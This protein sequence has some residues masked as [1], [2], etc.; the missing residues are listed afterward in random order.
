MS[1]LCKR[2]PDLSIVI[3]AYNIEDCITPMLDSLKAQ[4]IGDYLVE[5]IFVLNNC[6]DDTEGVIRRSGLDCQLI[7]CEIQGC[8]PARNAGLDIARGEY[9][10][11]IDGDDWLMSDTAIRQILDRVKRDN[12]DI[13]RIPFSH[14]KYRYNYFSM[15]WQYVMRREFIN[16]FR[17]PNYQPA[18]DDAFMEMVLRKAGLDRH[19]YMF[20]PHLSEELYYYNYLRPG[21]NMYRHQVLGEKI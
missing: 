4:D 13:L 21:S 12:V 15:V 10:W 5:I 17:F 6:T 7:N 3:P 19:T 2:D 1:T 20:L 18:E 11:T 14:D 8:G 9:I 16:E